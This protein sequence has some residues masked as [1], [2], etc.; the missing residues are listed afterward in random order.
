MNGT[1]IGLCLIIVAQFVGFAWLLMKKDT[2]I[3][4]LLDR[5]SVMRDPSELP[6]LA[7]HEAKV[8]EL[9]ERSS[10]KKEK[11]DFETDAKEF[12]RTLYDV[13]YPPTISPAEGKNLVSEITDYESQ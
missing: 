2:M 1:I 8:A 3:S 12:N 7:I 9:G 4:K 6:K 11:E 5:L 10:R 13:I